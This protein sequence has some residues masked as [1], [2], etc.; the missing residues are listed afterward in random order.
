LDA[1]IDLAR[2]AQS[3]GAA[4][5]VLPP[6]FFFRYDQ[7]DL[8]AWFCQFAIE[9]GSD[10]PLF[11]YRTPALSDE[12]TIELWSTGR[13]GAVVD[14]TGD[15]SSVD[16]LCAAGIA[17]IPADEVAAGRPGRC[18]VVSSVA[19]AVPELLAAMHR[20]ARAGAEPQLRELDHALREFLRW[21]ARFPEPTVVRLATS[22][23]GLK[24]GS[25]A[26]PLSPEKQKDL[27]SFRDWFQRW[28]PSVRK[29]AASV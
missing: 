4:A 15:P 20:A 13:F 21:S 7:D 25:L 28:L 18:A 26:V 3:A 9:L 22:L 2:E 23:R 11:V 14:A 17:V 24:T 8:R 1:S 19:C 12:T 27:D 16:R 29:L 6:P 10:P 5:L